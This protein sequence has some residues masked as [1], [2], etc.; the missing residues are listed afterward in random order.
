MTHLSCGQGIKN[1]IRRKRQCVNELILH[2]QTHTHKHTCIHTQN[3]IVFSLDCSHWLMNNAYWATVV[4]SRRHCRVTQRR[5]ALQ[6]EA[7]EMAYLSRRHSQP[8]NLFS[9]E[10]SIKHSQHNDSRLDRTKQN[11]LEYIVSHYQCEKWIT[12]FCNHNCWL[13]NCIIQ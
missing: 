5:A 1:G 9:I 8:L 10:F 3:S 13:F 4:L 12:L 7:S 6:R 2:A 11:C